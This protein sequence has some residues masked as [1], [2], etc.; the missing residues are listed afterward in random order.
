MQLQVSLN[1]VGDATVVGAVGELD[2]HT[3]PD[4]KAALDEAV[5]GDRDLIV[6]DLSGVDFM[7]STGLSVIISAVASLA[8]TKRSLRVV[9]ASPRVTKVFTLTGVDQQIPMYTSVEQAAVR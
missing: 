2:L 8:G 1:H 3:A 7:D 9:T 5:A 4:L 6:V